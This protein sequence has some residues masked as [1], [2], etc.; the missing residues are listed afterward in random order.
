MSGVHLLRRR[1][2]VDEDDGSPRRRQNRRSP[3]YGEALGAEILIRGST[4]IGAATAGF[5]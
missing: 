1:D 3:K 2:A 4:A 5:V